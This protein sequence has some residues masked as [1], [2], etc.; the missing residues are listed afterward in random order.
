MRRTP[1]SGRVAGFWYLLLIVLGHLRLIYIPNKLFVTGNAAATVASCFFPSA[2]SAN[3]A[4]AV[5]LVFLVLAF[6][7]LFAGVDRSRAVQEMIFRGVMPATLYFV[8]GVSDAAALMVV[9]EGDFPFPI[10]KASAG[11]AGHAVPQVAG[12]AKHR[13]RGSLGSMGSTVNRACVPI[14]ASCRGFWACGWRSA[15]SPTLP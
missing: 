5:S 7:R 4:G 9:R 1:D 13:R 8:N 14:A 10:R 3:L 2:S 11:R 6:Y 15:A 12:P